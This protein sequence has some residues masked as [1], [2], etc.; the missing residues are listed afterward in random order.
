MIFFGCYST[1]DDV[2]G[3]RLRRIPGE[4]CVECGVVNCAASMLDSDLLG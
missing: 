2:E 4:S 3:L 1:E